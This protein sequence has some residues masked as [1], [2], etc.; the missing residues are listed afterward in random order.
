M[1]ESAI[2]QCYFVC[3]SVRPSVRRTGDP[4]LNGL[5]YL[6]TYAIDSICMS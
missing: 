1:L 3:L 6:F 4:G 5:I 2:A